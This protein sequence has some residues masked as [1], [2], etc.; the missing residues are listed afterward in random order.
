MPTSVGSE[1]RQF[2]KESNLTTMKTALTIKNYRCFPDSKPLSFTL[3]EGLTGLLGINNSGKSTLLRF[4]LE[5]RS[6]F[7]LFT[8]A[9]GN[10]INALMNKTE[11]CHFHPSVEDHQEIFCNGNDRDLEIKFQFHLPDVHSIEPRTATQLTLSIYRKTRLFGAKLYVEGSEVTFIQSKPLEFKESRL[12]Y[13]G[14]TK[15]ETLA[16]LKLVFELGNDLYQSLYIGSFR[17]PINVGAKDDYYDI[18]VGQAFIRD[19][20]NYKTGSNKEHNERAFRVI[21][22]VKKI[23]GFHSLD[24]NPSSNDLTLQLFI[25]GKSFRLSELGSGLAHFILV[26][27]NVAIR[28]P[29]YVL[30][31]EP[32]LGLHPS[33]QLDFLTTLNSY[34]KK[35]VI[36]ATHNY[37]LARASADLV[38]S[39]LRNPDE[40][41]V[42]KPL[43]STPRLSEFLGELSYSGYQIL[44]FDKVLLVEGISEVKT[45]QQFL[46]QLRKDHQIVILPLGGKQFINANCEDQ[47]Q[48]L[49]R[50]STNIYA[51]I[52]SEKKSPNA[53][54][55]KARQEFEAVCMKTG[56]QCHILTMRATENYLT[57]AAIKQVMGQNYRAL[58]AYDALSDLKPS[59]SKT[60]NWRIARAMSLADWES[61]DLGNFL[62]AI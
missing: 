61:T 24:I 59:W 8:S 51:I 12:V 7:G 45:I 4:F 26:L 53:T 31:D 58:G 16:D 20:R 44:G 18:K 43:E 5:F 36:F 34:A 27:A 13:A 10:F 1:S 3:Q 54:L 38:Y 32:E 47:L 41:S 33:L 49:R 23:F 60:D 9:T 29:T 37:G 30:I 39:F 40:G 15:P 55:E 21:E 57:E 22:D 42:V 35:G 62:K 14:Q 48:E 52:D 46:R 28:Q 56:I 11:N 19:W 17:N 2:T 50:I 6:L 25:N